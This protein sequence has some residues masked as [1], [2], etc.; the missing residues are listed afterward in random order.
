MKTLGSLIRLA[1]ELRRLENGA[2]A[3]V[4]S[5]LSRAFTESLSELSGEE[6]IAPGQALR[7]LN[8][9]N[10]QTGEAIRGASAS[11]TAQ[12]I[13]IASYQSER[14][15]KILST[16]T[17]NVFTADGV[18]RDRLR[19]I[20]THDAIEG[21][22]AEQ[23]WRR[24]ESQTKLKTQRLLD[25]GLTK[26]LSADEI[27]QQINEL[28]VRPAMRQAEAL[29]RTVASNLGTAAQFE[30][31]E[32]NPHLTRGYRLLFTFDRRTSLICLAWSRKSKDKIYPY[33]P[34][35]PR[36]PMHWN[37]RTLIQPVLI[38]REDET[39]IEAGDWL[40]KQPEKTQDAILGPKRAE[41]FRKGRLQL[42]Q[43]IRSD[44][45]IATLAE[46][47]GVAATFTL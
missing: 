14:T 24:L 1:V 8:G 30:T 44:N 17:G 19:E 34:D 10:T 25:E 4:T 23:W 22:T 28:V 7:F 36:P 21:R 2:A 46:V 11:A 43:L 6:T 39:Q 13:E 31:A 38:G 47:R 35:S 3:L 42:D 15:A 5:P 27:K 20:L 29:T 9:F 32:A 33:A 40:T 41:M 37:C 45:S 12:A 18:G 16:A 26:R